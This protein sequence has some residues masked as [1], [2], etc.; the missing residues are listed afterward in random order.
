MACYGPHLVEINPGE[1]LEERV[2]EAAQGR[3]PAAAGRL[4]LLLM[5]GRKAGGELLFKPEDERPD[6]TTEESTDDGRSGVGFGGKNVGSLQNLINCWDADDG[7]F[8]YRA[9]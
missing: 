2:F 7:S 1:V 8:L 5:V 3:P 4:L 9:L 6:V